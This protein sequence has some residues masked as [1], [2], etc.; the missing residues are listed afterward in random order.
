MLPNVVLFAGT[1]FSGDTGLWVTNGT[2]AGT[3]ELTGIVG[4]GTGYVGVGIVPRLSHPTSHSIMAR[5]G[6]PASTRAA[7]TV[8]GK[9]TARPQARTS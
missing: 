4:A 8:C 2:A 6:S 1:D 7:K 3:Y 9:R 5:F